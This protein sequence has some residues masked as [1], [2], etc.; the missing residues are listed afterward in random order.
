MLEGGGAD[1]F[2]GLVGVLLGLGQELNVTILVD[3]NTHGLGVSK[4]TLGLG[5]SGSE[6]EGVSRSDNTAG[7]T[8]LN[9]EARVLVDKVPQKVVRY[10]SHYYCEMWWVVGFN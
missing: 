6:V 4:S 9:D 10:R 8:T 3:N 7:L 2:A 5:V 1:S